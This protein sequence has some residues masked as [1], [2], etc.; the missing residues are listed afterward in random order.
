MRK[1][2]VVKCRFCDYQLARRYRTKGG[3][4]RLGA[5][6]LIEHVN[7]AHPDEAARIADR[8]MEEYPEQFE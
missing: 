5:A 8:S 2:D 4:F 1:Q 6:M 7:H 3:K